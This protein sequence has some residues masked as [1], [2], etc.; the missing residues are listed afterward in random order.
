MIPY[1]SFTIASHSHFRES[2]L[3]WEKTVSTFGGRLI[4]LAEWNREDTG[5]SL[6]DEIIAYCEAA[7]GVTAE[8]GAIRDGRLRVL[9]DDI[10]YEHHLLLH[11]PALP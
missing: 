2:A 6:R 4:G 7:G 8:A 1:R 5:L 9:Q 10:P 11:Q 3:A